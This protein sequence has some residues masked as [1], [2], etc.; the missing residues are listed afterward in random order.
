MRVD[1]FRSH[2]LSPLVLLALACGLPE[3]ET[4]PR[5]G[6]PAGGDGAAEPGGSADSP[7]AVG[8]P[9]DDLISGEPP[10]CV[11]SSSAAL[12]AA[13]ESCTPTPAARTFTRAVCS[14]EDTDVAGFLRTRSFRSSEDAPGTERLGGSVGVNRH[15][16]TG[17]LADVGGSFVI[18]GARDTIF[19][20]LL[21]VGGDLRF[22][23]AFD[24]AGLVDVGGDA[25]L[26][27]SLRA[28]SIIDIHGDLHRSQESR[29]LGLALVQVGGAEYRAPVDVPPPCG[30]APSDLLD[31]AGAVDDAREHNDNAAIGL[32]PHALDLTVG[33]G[34][35]ITLPTGRYYVDQVGSLG[36]IQLRISGRVALYVEDDFLAGPLFAVRI[37]PG[38][39]LDLYVRDTFALAGA[40]ILGDPARPAATRIYVGG[41]GDI[42][43]AGINA[44]A[45]NL[46]APGANVLVGG[47][48]KVFGS[49]F[50]KNVIAA[51]FLD[52]GFDASVTDGVDCTDP[53]SP[54]DAPPGSDPPNPDS[55]GDDPPGSPDGDPSAGDP[56]DDG[57]PPGG[58][59]S[60][61]GDPSDDG[62]PPTSS[63]PED[64]PG[65]D[66][67]G[68][69]ANPCAPGDVES[70][71]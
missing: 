59:P 29:F 6:Q 17:G 65:S 31:V 20:G 8:A 32:D 61:D 51:G 14:C 24:V 47:F 52:V 49:V 13:R 10:S 39:E 64:S 50:G 60:D 67:P 23:P 38:A 5:E 33:I 35:A 69:P 46:Y 66:P 45:G 37:D 53:G 63:P 56:S 40:A 15:Y 19:G 58:N 16:L 43:V 68:D 71:Y 9:I 70:P 3:V 55:P 28:L 57:N 1:I 12:A 11:S 44:F 48:G 27:G 42:A 2:R 54:G 7:G 18:A 62:N 41:T 34:T 4:I 30:C 26:G 36:A 22:N 21:K 25:H